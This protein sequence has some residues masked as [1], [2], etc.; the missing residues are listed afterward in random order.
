MVRSAAA[1]RDSRGSAWLPG[2]SRSEARFVDRID[3]GS[4]I[5]WDADGDMLRHNP[6]AQDVDRGSAGNAEVL[7]AGSDAPGHAGRVDDR[8][9]P[10]SV[11][12]GAPP[13]E[14]SMSEL[15]AE[16]EIRSNVHNEASPRRRMPLRLRIYAFLASTIVTFVV[17]EIA[18]RMLISV[19]DFEY[20]TDG[21]LLWKNRPNQVVRLNSR[22]QGNTPGRITIDEFGFR[23]TLP[24]QPSDGRRVLALGDSAMFGQLLDDAETFCSRLKALSGGKLE[25]TNASVPGW[26]LFQCEMLLRDK[27]ETMRPEIVVVHY[28]SF[29]VLRQ[30]FP[31]EEPERRKNFLLESRV[32]NAIRHYSKL[33]YL[34]SKLVQVVILQRSGR[35]VVTEV[36][37]DQRASS[38]GEEPS[39]AYRRCWAQDRERLISMAK[40]AEAH[41]AK[42]VIVPGSPGDCMPGS[43]SS[44]PNVRYFFAQ[45]EAMAKEYGM[46]YV[47]LRPVMQ[48]HDLMELTL[49]PRDGHPSALWNRLVAEEIYRTLEAAGLLRLN[50]DEARAQSSVRLRR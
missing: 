49:L 28:Q 16:N 48:G 43:Y 14:V 37:D 18:V 12:G 4:S 21:E 15:K 25:V 29:D 22:E 20:V 19:H 2:G 31:P 30:P 36:V 41:G 8:F 23:R 6:L 44:R 32:K 10:H 34:L 38:A 13:I 39:A 3:S 45:I 27:I 35:G 46:I 24:V 11:E 1:H 17:G 5:N 9:Q 40:L 50:Q 26:G 47:N 42:F 7:E 33:A